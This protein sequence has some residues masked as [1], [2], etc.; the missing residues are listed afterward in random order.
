MNNWK[1]YHSLTIIVIMIGIF[2]VA[3]S[4]KTSIAMRWLIVMGLMLAFLYIA[5]WGITGAHQP[6]PYLINEQLRMSTSRFQMSL[7]MILIL[8]AYLVAVFANIRVGHILETSLGIAI[9]NELWIALGISTVALVGSPLINSTKK[10]KPTNEIEYAKILTDEDKEVYNAAGTTNAEKT[11]LQAKH[12]A[13]QLYRNED[14]KKSRLY[15]IISGEE[16]GNCN[17]LDLARVQVLFFTMILVVTYGVTIGNLFTEVEI[18]IQ[19]VPISAFPDL[20]VSGSALLALSTGGYLVGK[21]VSQTPEAP[22]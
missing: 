11:V 13:G 7:W 16:I 6:F 3:Y 18:T 5:G 1:W 2:W 19:N 22:P 10:N 17:V 4:L 12:A 14:P 21:T 8:S 20:G 15:E 9:P